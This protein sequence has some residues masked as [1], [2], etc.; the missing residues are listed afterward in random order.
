MSSSLWI[1][2]GVLVLQGVSLVL[3]AGSKTRD[4]ALASEVDQVKRALQAIQ[5]AAQKLK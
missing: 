2:L 1:A 4:T 3:H 5:D